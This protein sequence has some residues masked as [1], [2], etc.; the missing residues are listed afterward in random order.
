MRQEWAAAW[1]V[2]SE[3]LAATPPTEPSLLLVHNPD[4]MEMMGEQAVDL[5][6][7]GHTHGGQVV[8]PFLGPLLLPSC[9]GDKYAS[10]LVH[11]PGGPVYVSR[12]VG[13]IEPAVRWNCPPEVAVVTLRRG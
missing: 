10:G 1:N 11:S 5:A 4:F 3:V 7:A 13:L 12:G 6:L 2:V 8:L 9:F